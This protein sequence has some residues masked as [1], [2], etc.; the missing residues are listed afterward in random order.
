MVAPAV[1]MP[2]VA[3]RRAATVA[4]V[5]HRGVVTCVADM[6]AKTLARVMAAHRIHAV[7]HSRRNVSLFTRSA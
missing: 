2:F 6:A 5:M 1:Q 4:D 7:D 3:P